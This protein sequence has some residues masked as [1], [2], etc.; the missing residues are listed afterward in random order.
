MNYTNAAGSAVEESGAAKTSAK[1]WAE[2]TD[3]ARVEVLRQEVRFLKRVVASVGLMAR[4]AGRRVEE[5]E[6]GATGRA[7]FPAERGAEGSVT[8]GYDPLA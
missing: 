6:H 3:D 8:G 4:T 2:L 7:L 5:H 1:A